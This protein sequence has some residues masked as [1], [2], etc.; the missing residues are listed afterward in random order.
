MKALLFTLLRSFVFE[1]STPIE[2][3]AT[4]RYISSR[5]Y[6]H[7]EE[8][9]GVQLPLKVRRYAVDDDYE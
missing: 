3:V 5:P 7:S 2:D 8:N 9:K 4:M 6:L 1:L